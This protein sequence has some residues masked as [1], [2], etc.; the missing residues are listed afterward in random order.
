MQSSN[1]AAVPTQKPRISFIADEKLLP[2][3]KE[4]ADQEYRTVSN[5]VEAILKDAVDRRDG[6]QAEVRK[7]LKTLRSGVS[8]ATLLDAIATLEKGLA[9]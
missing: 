9:D 6:R 1:T 2:K 8:D 4:W 3:L 7:A 5:L